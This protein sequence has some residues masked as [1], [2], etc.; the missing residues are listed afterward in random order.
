MSCNYCHKPVVTKSYQSCDPCDKPC[1]PVHLC[2]PCAK[3]AA[4]TPM[5]QCEDV[6][7]CTEGCEETANCSCVIYKGNPLST[8]NVVD[9]D[10]LCSILTKIDQL[11]R[12]ILINTANIP[13]YYYQVSCLTM[14]SQQVIINSV[15]KN[16]VQQI[17]SPTLYP[18]AIS[19]LTYLHTLDPL[20]TF[21]SPNTFSTTGTDNWE[22]NITCV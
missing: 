6:N 14:P 3:I 12:A 5:A 13:K 7:Y 2:D 18:N 11:F 10:D 1:N 22:L 19:A 15:K 4:L 21:T 17:S 8:L 9:T 16:G 20:F